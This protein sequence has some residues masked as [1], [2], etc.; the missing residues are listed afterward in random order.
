MKNLKDE[1]TD[2]TQPR[3]E[4]LFLVCVSGNGEDYNFLCRA[5]WRMKTRDRDHF[6]FQREAGECRVE[7][8]RVEYILRVNGQ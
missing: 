5:V 6:R 2:G 4:G 8:E 3:K 1:F 7:P